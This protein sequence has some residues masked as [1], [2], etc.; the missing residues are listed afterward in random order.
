MPGTRGGGLGVMSNLDRV[1]LGDRHRFPQPRQVRVRIGIAVV[2]EVTM[3]PSLGTSRSPR[4]RSAGTWNCRC[5]WLPRCTTSCGSGV[6]SSDRP[7]RLTTESREAFAGGRLLAALPCT[8]WAA[9]S[10]SSSPSAP[11]GPDE[12][13]QVQVAISR[14]FLAMRSLTPNFNE[15]E[16]AGILAGTSHQYH[17]HTTP[18]A[19]PT[20]TGS[21]TGTLYTADSRVAPSAPYRC[22]NCRQIFTVGPG[23]RFP[24]IAAPKTNTCPT[25]KP[26]ASAPCP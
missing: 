4:G 22:A 20:I 18:N 21:H 12:T 17:L 15:Y 8:T 14:M 2:P 7:T 16:G 5:R 26:P 10:T 1:Q 24:T 25:A 3:R 13:N 6:V 19:H 11:A 9:A 23:Q